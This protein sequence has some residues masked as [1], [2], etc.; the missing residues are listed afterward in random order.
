HKSALYIWRYFA[1]FSN[2]EHNWLV[3]DNVQHEPRKVAASVSPTNVGL[4]LNARQVANELG[5]V[6]TPE[7]LDLTQKTLGTIVRLPKYRGHLM[8][9]YDTHTLEAKPPFFV[10]SVDS[11]NLVA[12]LWTMQQGCL[13]LLDRP[14]LQ[15]ELQDGFLDHLYLLASLRVLPRRKFSAMKRELKR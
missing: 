13:E 11:G 9:W 6:T 14:L 12:S 10:S 15:P 4:L 5:Y 7:M 8:N 1:E 2:E 3:P